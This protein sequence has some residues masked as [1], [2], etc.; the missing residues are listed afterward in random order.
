MKK[1]ILIGTLT[2]IMLPTMVFAD[3]NSEVILDK[4][5]AVEQSISIYNDNLAYVKDV[6]NFRLKKGNTSVAFVGVAKNMKP[7]T[8]M[9]K[10]DGVT[11]LEQNYDYNIITPNSVLEE[12]VGKKVKTVMTNPMSG[13]DV[14]ADAIL[15]DNKNGPILQFEYGIETNFP[16]RVIIPNIPNNLRTKPTLVANLQNEEFA[17]KNVEL[18]YLTNGITWKADYVANVKDKKNI[19]LTSFVTINNDSGIDYNNVSVNLVSG[20]I[21]QVSEVSHR[22]KMMKMENSMVMSSPVMADTAGM[23]GG[24]EQGTVGEYH[25]YSVPDKTTIKDNQTKQVK[26]F[27]FDDVKYDTEYKFSSPLG[28]SYYSGNEEFKK[29]NPTTIYKIKNNKDSNLGVPVPKGVIRFYENDKNGKSQFVG[30]SNINQ[31]AVNED[32]E[33]LLGKS[34]DVFAT[35]KVIKSTDVSDK[36]KDLDVKIT[37]NNSK[38]EDVKVSF[39]QGIYG[40]SLISENLKSLEKTSNVLK[41]EIDIKKGE[42]VD[43]E[44]KV[45]VRK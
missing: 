42:A 4:D 6:R 26:L 31:L 29:E 18:S 23:F 24:I 22:P 14:F 32:T 43:L 28:V 16:G 13:K 10:S 20:S 2:A 30:E 40:G 34:V 27:Y 5:S 35:G 21:N 33:L 36:L 45:R 1:Y 44:F 17:Q 8:A 39:E 38:D 3:D 15:L 12:F 41:W 19:S 25:I 9:I 37:I 11:V 7:E